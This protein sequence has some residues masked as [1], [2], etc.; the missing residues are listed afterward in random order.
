MSEEGKGSTKWGLLAGGGASRGAVQ[1]GPLAK[2]YGEFGPPSFAVGT[3][4]GAVTVSA[5][6]DVLRKAW[7]TVDGAC[8]F[9]KFSWTPWKGLYTLGRLRRLL[10]EYDACADLPCP[11]WVGCY[12]MSHQRY[13]LIALHEIQDVATRRDAVI[14]SCSIPIIHHAWKVNGRPLADGGVRSVLGRVPRS[15]NVEDLDVIN[16]LA[17][18][19]V[20]RADRL[21]IR[22]EKRVTNLLGQLEVCYEEWQ[23]SVSVADMDYLKEISESV[24]VQLWSP[25]EWKEIGSPFEAD[26]ERIANR[27]SLGESLQPRQITQK[28][29]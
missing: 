24:E 14:A 17:C 1:V 5:H 18:S 6:P 19:P 25:S 15:I 27:L 7:D 29:K 10:D 2:L 3:S 21:K 11:T 12:D 22:E 28:S 16:A 4:I 13:E 23:S 20:G 9:Q 8:S 26:R